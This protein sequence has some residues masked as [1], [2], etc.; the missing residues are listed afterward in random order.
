VDTQEAEFAP[1]RFS[2]DD[3]VEGDRLP[4][5][6]DFFGP[7]IFRAEIEPAAD[8]PFYA[9]VTVRRLPGVRL[10]SASSSLARLS[11]TPAHLADGSDHLCLVVSSSAGAAFDR[12]RE[13][14]YRAGDAL[15]TSAA[16]AATTTSPTTAHYRGVFIRP[17]ALAPLVPDLGGAVLRA[18]PSSSEALQYLLT[19]ARL[20]EN[21]RTLVDPEVARLA[22][23]HVGD[24]FALIVGATGD[25]AHVAAGRGLRAARL[26][27]IRSYIARNSG[28]HRLS[29]TIVAARYCV[30]PRYVQRLFE[31]EGTTFS[32]F[33]LNQRLARAH[34]MLAD[35]RYARETIS[36]IAFEAGFGDVSYF[37]RC[38][39]RRFHET[40]S[41]V[42]ADAASSISW[43]DRLDGDAQL[44]SG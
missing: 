22:A 30:T 19:Y 31:A 14:T 38:F 36:A 35:P 25:A 27:A 33:L 5:W 3:L 18:I 2:T 6:R 8:V 32:E 39:H 7:R 43:H 28:D 11:R 24:L 37:N 40:P 21:R 12:D 15:L 16:L 9:D 34:Q 13:V 4:A 26:Q 42:R 23:V 17:A 1:I 41:D 29:V 44:R 10:M 20:L